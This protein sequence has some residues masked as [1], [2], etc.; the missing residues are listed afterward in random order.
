MDI[1]L[2]R[3]AV[4]EEVSAS[5]RDADRALTPDGLRRAERVARG[6]AALE[7]S[8]DLVLTSP[9]RR[10]RQTAEPAARAL[11]LARQFRGAGRGGGRGPSG[12]PRAASGSASRHPRRGGPRRPSAQEGDCRLGRARGGRGHTQGP[13]AGPRARADSI[14]SALRRRKQWA[15]LLSAVWVFS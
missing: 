6:L 11:G 7:P 9:Y 5:G 4:A 3:H 2:L 1:W 12:G 10:A 8:I 15:S 14:E 13:A